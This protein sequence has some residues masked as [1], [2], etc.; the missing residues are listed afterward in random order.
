MAKTCP[1]TRSNANAGSAVSVNKQK[2]RKKSPNEQA[3]QAAVRAT[4]HADAVRDFDGEEDND[5]DNPQ[6]R[7]EDDQDQEEDQQSLDGV[8]L[9]QNDGEQAPEAGVPRVAAP[10]F[11]YEWTEKSISS[12]PERN[13]RSGNKIIEEAELPTFKNS[14]SVG[15]NRAEIRRKNAIKEIDFLQL[16]WTNELIDQMIKNSNWYGNTFLRTKGWFDLTRSEFKAFLA[17]VMEL[18]RVK[19]PSREA[20]FDK[21]HSG[22]GFIK[23]VGISL[24]RFNHIV[25]AWRYEDFSKLTPD[26]IAEKKRNDPFWP[27]K[28][29]AEDLAL[30][31]QSMYNC[32]QGLDIDEQT[33]PF[34]G[35]HKCRCYNPKKIYK[36]H[37]KIYSLNDS[38][39]GYQANFFLYQG[40]AEVRPEG[41]AATLWP[42]MKLLSDP[43][44]HN[45]GHIVCTDN[46]YTSLA[47]LLFCASIACA[48]VGTIKINKSGIPEAGKFP[49]T[50][51]GVKRRGTMKQMSADVGTGNKAITAYFTAWQDNKPVHILSSIPTFRTTV[52]R[53]TEL[54]G[55]RWIRTAIAIPTVIRLYNWLMGGTDSMDQRLSYYRPHLKSV[56]WVPRM[57]CHLLNVSTVNAYILFKEYY[58]KGNTYHLLDFI[59]ALIPQLAEGFIEEKNALKYRSVQPEYVGPTRSWRSK[60]TWENDYLSRIGGNHDCVIV[61]KIRP[62]N[63][64]QKEHSTE[65]GRCIICASDVNTRCK[66][67]KVALCIVEDCDTVGG[68]CF[69]KFHTLKKFP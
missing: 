2:K 24:E 4:Q 56:S 67:C 21:S 44:W 12:P 42:V 18:G 40:K 5:V 64:S 49:K 20:A 23:I 47:V 7:E 29:M 39:S 68:T 27:I 17:I 16:F 45:K 36:W 59:N 51:A 62:D 9:P 69:H 41:V 14:G 65:R 22:S 50:G 53:Q 54:P 35:R 43:K 25:K 63:A 38:I 19:F 57:L 26:E 13:T 60:L 15:P 30:N 32:R 34:K 6:P 8:D 48:F 10:N 3:P 31:F 52:Q 55:G 1:Q 11:N 61:K 37:F 46:W 33:V 66:Q 58:G 28:K